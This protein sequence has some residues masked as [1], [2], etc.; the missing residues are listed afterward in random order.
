MVPSP[1]LVA[2]IDHAL[3][4]SFWSSQS[5][6]GGPIKYLIQDHEMNSS[7]ISAQRDAYATELFDD[8]R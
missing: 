7:E 1:V 3:G 6:Q 8:I 2:T 5:S 4:Y